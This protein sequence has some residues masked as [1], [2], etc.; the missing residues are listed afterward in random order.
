MPGPD[1]HIEALRH[2][3]PALRHAPHILK[4]EEEKTVYLC[5][6]GASGNKPFCD[7]VTP[8]RAPEPCI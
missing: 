2:Q 8:R 4:L 5:N 1:G 3:P 6:C 7:A